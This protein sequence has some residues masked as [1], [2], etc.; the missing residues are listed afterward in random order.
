MHTTMTVI[1]WLKHKGNVYLAADSR[2]SEWDK[3]ITDRY[4]KIIKAF[5]SYIWLAWEVWTFSTLKYVLYQLRE[6]KI[7]IEKEEDVYSLYNALYKH[8][9]ETWY[10]DVWT[11]LP[12][13]AVIATRKWK[14]FQLEWDWCVIEIKDFYATWS[15]WT[16]AD[17][18]LSQIII[19]NPEND[20]KYIMKEVFKK[21]SWCWWKINIKIMPSLKSAKVIK[22]LL[23]NKKAK[24]E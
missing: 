21:H 15:W 8:A 13:S 14:I 11:V 24:W 2:I 22:K 4:E 12:L 17:A 18:L 3:I 6:N 1:I 5:D 16:V 7:S 20:I 23:N 19:K 9:R 10:I